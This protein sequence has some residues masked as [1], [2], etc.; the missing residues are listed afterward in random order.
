MRCRAPGHTVQTDAAINPGN[1][2]GALVDINGRVIGL[3]TAAA[4]LSNSASGSIGVG[5]AIPIGNA[6]TVAKT[7]TSEF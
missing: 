3:V 5:F 1:S 2:G 6:I 4:S 7:L